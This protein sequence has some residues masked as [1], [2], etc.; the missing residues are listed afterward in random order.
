MCRAEAFSGSSVV[1]ANPAAETRWGGVGSCTTLDVVTL[2]AN[3]EAEARK[4]AGSCCVSV[5]DEDGREGGQ[6][7]AGQRDVDHV[8]HAACTS[9]LD[10][11]STTEVWPCSEA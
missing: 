3:A 4:G 7:D 5:N 2:H 6:F 1:R 10:A 11:A 9:R 8:G